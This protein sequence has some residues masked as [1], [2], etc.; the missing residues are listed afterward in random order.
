MVNQEAVGRCPWRRKN[1]N[2]FHF[3]TSLPFQIK[4]AMIKE[5]RKQHK[6]SE[7]A[8]TCAL[9]QCLLR[10]VSTLKTRELF[11]MGKIYMRHGNMHIH[12]RIHTPDTL[13]VCQIT[14]LWICSCTH[15]HCNPNSRSFVMESPVLSR[16]GVP[17]TQST[18]GHWREADVRTPGSIISL[19]NIHCS[20]SWRPCQIPALQTFSQ[21]CFQWI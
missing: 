6:L 18:C 5:T 7:K 12:T 14:C 4:R 9:I 20:R 1:F 2:K 21:S 17:F 8:S 15:I 11:D 10:Q 16:G 13:Q 3:Y 19:A